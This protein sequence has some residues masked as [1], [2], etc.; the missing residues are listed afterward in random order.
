[1][2]VMVR[3][4]GIPQFIELAGEI[5]DF[6]KMHAVNLAEKG[7]ASVGKKIN[8]SL[9][10]VIGLTYKKEFDDTRESP[11]QKIIEE[12]KNKEKA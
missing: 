1:M 12:I 7:L 2:K 3:I 6:M 9:I 8:Q 5:N 10:A 11:A 4:I